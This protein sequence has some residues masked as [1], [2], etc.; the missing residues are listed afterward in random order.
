MATA[1][2]E[3][4]PD[5]AKQ[6]NSSISPELRKKAE[7]ILDYYPPL[8]PNGGW[9][10][11]P[12]EQLEKIREAQIQRIA[13]GIKAEGI[14]DNKKPARNRAGGGGAPVS[15]DQ[16]PPAKRMLQRFNT[17]ADDIA[18][19]IYDGGVN[20]FQKLFSK[21]PD[22]MQPMTQEEYEKQKQSNG[23]GIN[24]SRTPTLEDVQYS[25]YYGHGLEYDL[26]YNKR[27]NDP[28]YNNRSGRGRGI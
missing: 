12:A 2:V 6:P 8:N 9:E 14:E 16:E 17:F 27:A 22:P 10:G 1:V 21:K 4:T 19:G 24:G 13:E 28:L 18:N 11:L 23:M 20:L 3:Q 25:Q 15:P 7:S 26:K 5:T